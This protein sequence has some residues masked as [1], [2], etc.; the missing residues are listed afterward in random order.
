MASGVSMTSSAPVHHEALQAR[1]MY[2]GVEATPAEPVQSATPFEPVARTQM[3]HT[4]EAL[5][6]T[7]EN[8]NPLQARTAY[9]GFE[10]PAGPMQSA[11]SWDTTAQS[12]GA[13]LRRTSVERPAEQ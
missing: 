2:S 11:A 3:S 6:P 4:F 7:R 12:G 1:E 9:S 8:Y 10:A 13:P 5:E